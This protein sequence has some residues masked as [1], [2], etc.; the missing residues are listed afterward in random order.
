[1]QIQNIPSETVETSGMLQFYVL[2]ELI[3]PKRKF[4]KGKR[5]K[6]N[7]CRLVVNWR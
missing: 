3:S 1:M 5:L 4:D 6:C 7:G 2:F